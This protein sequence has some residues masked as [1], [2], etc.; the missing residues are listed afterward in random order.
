MVSHLK[1]SGLKYQ[2]RWRADRTMQC[3]VC[4]DPAIG[5]CQACWKFYCEAHGDRICEQC[6][7]EQVEARSASS[8]WAAPSTKRLCCALR[9]PT[10]RRRRG[11]ESGRGCD[12]MAAQPPAVGAR[13]QTRPNRR[14]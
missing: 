6:R 10:N 8:S 2:F 14:V 9:T 1:F 13:F 11:T 3:Y 5:Q 4:A 7:P 12:I